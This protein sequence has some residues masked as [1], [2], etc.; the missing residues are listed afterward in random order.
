MKKLHVD[1]KLEPD[2]DP[3]HRR[4]SKSGASQKRGCDVKSP[5]A[6][7]PGLRTT[8]TAGEPADGARE[9]HK[10]F[11]QEFSTRE[12]IAAAATLDTR[13]SEDTPPETFRLLVRLTPCCPIRCRCICS[14][15]AGVYPRPPSLNRLSLQ[16]VLCC[17]CDVHD[18][19]SLTGGC[20]WRDSGNDE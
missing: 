8:K 17:A 4:Y 13:I 20:A 15:F 18:K 14:C 5:S 19:D 11:G 6:H 9:T 7:S 1:V 10:I 16:A 3:G 2:E 12:I